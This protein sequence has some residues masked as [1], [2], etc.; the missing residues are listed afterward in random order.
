MLRR[1]KS[2]SCDNLATLS[3]Y[4]ADYS[5]EHDQEYCYKDQPDFKQRKKSLNLFSPK[6]MKSSLVRRSSIR[7]RRVNS[8]SLV[9][10]ID[11]TLTDIRQKLAMFRE[12]DMKLRKRMNSLSSSIENLTSSSQSGPTQPSEPAELVPDVIIPDDDAT[13][14]QQYKDDQTIENKIKKLPEL[15]VL[16]R[17]PSLAVTC[18]R[19]M[20]ASAPSLHETAV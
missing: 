16:N 18:Y 2:S 3:L 10:N 11:I 17:L 19:T 13:E 1:K 9:D 7:C 20:Y 14:E 15:C 5:A 4:Y 6:K 12:Q 8:G